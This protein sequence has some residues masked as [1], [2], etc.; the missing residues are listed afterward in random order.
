MPNKNGLICES[1]SRTL[2]SIEI[3]RVNWNKTGWDK[4]SVINIVGFKK[5]ISQSKTSKIIV[6]FTFSR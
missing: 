1:H 6:I 5:T 2:E 4:M 3:N